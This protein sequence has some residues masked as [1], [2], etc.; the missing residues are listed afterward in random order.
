MSEAGSHQSIDRAATLLR[1]LHE[2]TG[3][4]RVND[5]AK[6]TGLG[7]STTSRLLAALEA[8]DLVL[9]DEHTGLCRLGSA[10]ITF[11]GTAL[12]QRPVYRHGRVI[13]QRL[14]SALDLEVT[15]A[16]RRE[17]ALFY[18]CSFEGGTAAHPWS[19]LGELAPLHATALG[20]SVLVDL[21][22]GE[23]RAL[24]GD[25][26]RFTRNTIVEHD[27]LDAEL[28]DVRTRGY[29]DERGELALGRTA[30]AATIRDADGDV[31]G[32]IAVGGPESALDL[33]GREGELGPAVIEAADRISV[34]LGFR[35][36]PV[37][38]PD[39]K[40]KTENP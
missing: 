30:I 20:K 10:L 11:G 4:L 19:R 12:N 31:V 28:E 9:R 34:S 3:G 14:A 25:L 17:D 13:A 38:P 33:P 22:P 24:L 2:A 23:R 36:R 21:D 39:T 26:A 40:G 15:I 7:P 18:F 6:L 32:G 35:S 5:V 27:R 1:V 16:A 8:H 29:A 37:N